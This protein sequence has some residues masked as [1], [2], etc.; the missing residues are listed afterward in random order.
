MSS[1]QDEFACDFCSY[2]CTDFAKFARHVRR[3]EKEASFVLRCYHCPR[4][5]TSLRYWRQHVT[6]HRHL[7]ATSTSKSQDSLNCDLA[8][9]EENGGCSGLSF[10]GNSPKDKDT[11]DDTDRLND[12]ISAWQ[13]DIT[14]F[15]IRLRSE[16][17]LK[18]SGCTEVSA[19]LQNFSQQV[20]EESRDWRDQPIES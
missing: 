11:A 13:R 18:N 6:A 17:G 8:S 2:I 16:H 19:F 20:A 14:S 12:K 1:F 3:H 15:L 5:Y 4:K 7:P 9:V 10:E